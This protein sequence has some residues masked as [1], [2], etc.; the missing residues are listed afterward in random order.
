M[1]SV[2][3]YWDDRALLEW[4][5]ELGADEAISETP[6]NRYE[7]EASKPKVAASKAGGGKQDRPVPIAVQEVDTVAAATAAAAGASDLAT[8][9]S[10]IETFDH[11]QLKK[12]ARKIVFGAGQSAARVMIIGESPSRE[13][14][15]AGKPFA[16]VQGDLLGKMTDAIGLSLDAEDPTKAVYLTTAM[17]WRVPGDGLPVATDLAM[18]CP[19]LERHIALVNPDVVILMGN[20]PCQMLLGKNGI[21]RL[22]GKW[23]EIAGRLVMPMVHP[24]TLMKTPIAKRDAWA[25]LLEVQAKLRSLTK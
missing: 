18:M 21:S 22:R 6:I 9:K 11:C 3:T 4:Q 13:E 23:A 7:L 25:D 19:F 20:T 1:D 24:L 17:P 5:L 10:A 2:S 15:V 14:D 8:L 16:G 12:G